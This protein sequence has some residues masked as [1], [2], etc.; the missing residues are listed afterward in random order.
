MT[1]AKRA[2]MSKNTPSDRP[3]LALAHAAPSLGLGLAAL[4]AV[5]LLGACHSNVPEPEP[6]PAAKP[7]AVGSA[8]PIATPEAAPT[9]P[10]AEPAPPPAPAAEAAAPSNG[11]PLNGKFTLDDAT[12]GLAGK[13]AI[14][15]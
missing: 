2:T 10:P 9:P 12:A 14:S 5:A 1:I 3:R 13:G 4:V 15:A 8:A 11:D 7:Q 6:N